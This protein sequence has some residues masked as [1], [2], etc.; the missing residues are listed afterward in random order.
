MKCNGLTRF[1]RTA[2]GTLRV[3]RLRASRS[4]ARLRRQ[5]CRS[6]VGAHALSMRTFLYCG[7]DKRIRQTQI[8]V[9]CTRV[10]FPDPRLCASRSDARLRLTRNVAFGIQNAH[11]KVGCAPTESTGFVT[12]AIQIITLTILPRMRVYGILIS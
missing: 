3:P 1:A 2:C 7:F 12:K 4:D 8:R 5:R 6:T 9:V 11:I 10:T